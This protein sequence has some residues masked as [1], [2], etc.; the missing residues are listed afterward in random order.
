MERTKCEVFSRSMGFIRPIDN[1][2]IGKRAEFE[3]RRLFKE[4][5]CIR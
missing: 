3:E 1:F 4:S 2:N 5:K